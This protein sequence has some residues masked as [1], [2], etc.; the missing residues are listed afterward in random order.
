MEKSFIAERLFCKLN[1]LTIH[2]CSRFELLSEIPSNFIRHAASYDFTRVDGDLIR[3]L[4]ETV[5]TE[6]D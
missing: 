6:W 3:S 2:H 5:N 1:K 4:P